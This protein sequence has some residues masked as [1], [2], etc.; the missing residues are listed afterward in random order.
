MLA[1]SLDLNLDKRGEDKK[2][3]DDCLLPLILSHP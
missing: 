1:I 2:A 3:D